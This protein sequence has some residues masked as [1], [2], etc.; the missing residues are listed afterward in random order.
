MRQT[1]FHDV[2]AI[3]LLQQR[4]VD[5]LRE[6]AFPLDADAATALDSH[7]LARTPARERMSTLEFWYW[8]YRAMLQYLA[9]RHAEAAASL[10]T[11]GALAWSSAGPYPSGRF[12]SLSR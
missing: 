8:L 12:P 6:A 7:D 3:L 9:G 4:F 1:G 2:E 5:G 10:E 11:A